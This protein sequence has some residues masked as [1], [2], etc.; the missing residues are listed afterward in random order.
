MLN[1]TVP[2]V[3]GLVPE[4][5]FNLLDTHCGQHGVGKKHVPDRREDAHDG[6]VDHE[7]VAFPHE[8]LT[9]PQTDPCAERLEPLAHR[10]R[11]ERNGPPDPA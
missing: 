11:F 7:A 4:N 6:R 1:V 9:T 10:T 2:H 5:R 3:P 8:N